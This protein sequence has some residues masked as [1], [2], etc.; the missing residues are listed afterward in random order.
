MPAH[1]LAW[2]QFCLQPLK[3]SDPRIG[4]RSGA[5]A[6]S[7]A[8]CLCE[9]CGDP[10]AH[11]FER[12]CVGGA[13]H[14]IGPAIGTIRKAIFFYGPLDWHVTGPEI[15]ARERVAAHE[16]QVKQQNRQPETIVV[17]CSA[18]TAKISTL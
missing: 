14:S 2:A 17:Y 3:R 4:I 18:K 7:P 11:S 5:G 6:S 8:K 13:F 9:K 16:E 10:G 1:P 12:D 15:P